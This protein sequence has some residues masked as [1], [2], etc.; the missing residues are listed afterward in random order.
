MKLLT[1]L[2]MVL[3]FS[4]SIASAEHN[5][6]D[7][8]SSRSDMRS[9]SRNRM[10]TLARAYDR[11]QTSYQYGKKEQ[12]VTELQTGL[13]SLME[14]GLAYFRTLKSYAVMRMITKP[15]KWIYFA[16]FGSITFSV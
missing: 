6:S 4:I 3:C 15:F 14:R 13:E 12:A 16:S 8:D 5:R 10:A 11:A 1:T 7:F 2:L 9:W